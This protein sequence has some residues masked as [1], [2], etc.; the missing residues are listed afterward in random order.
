MDQLKRFIERNRAAFDAGELP[1]GHLERFSSKLGRQ[2]RPALRRH[3][4]RYGIVGACAAAALLLCL[5]GR[6]I[7]D[8]ASTPVCPATSELREIQIYYHMQLN[9]ILEQIEALPGT[10]D[11]LI[12]KRQILQEAA[13]ILSRQRDFENKVIP[14]L[15]CT[16]N[17]VFVLDQY[18]STTVRS[19]RFMLSRLETTDQP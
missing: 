9:E 5:T 15:P 13:R 12:E 16:D 6:N 1:P 4:L 14:E 19:F 10:G 3:L 8:F 7:Y 18:Y 11:K 2:P 17:A